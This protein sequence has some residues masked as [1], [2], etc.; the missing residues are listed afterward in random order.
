MFDKAIQSSFVLGAALLTSLGAAYGL[1]HLSSGGQA[2][3]AVVSMAPIDGAPASGQAAQVVR[4]ADG[5]YWAEAEI[6]GRAVRVLVDTGATVV[7]LT[8]QD[9]QRLGL[10]VTPDDFNRAVQTAS[11]EAKAASVTLASVSVAGATV[12]KVEALVVE[13]GLAHSLLGMSY[14]GRLSRFEAS[15]AGLTLRP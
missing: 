7:A 14:L 2:Q 10:K 13:E 4:G 6:D 1:N 9:A 3:A 12:R 11:G 15:P 5:H 8:R